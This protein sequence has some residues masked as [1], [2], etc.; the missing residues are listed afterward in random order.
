MVTNTS[1]QSFPN[2]YQMLKSPVYNDCLTEEMRA[3]FRRRDKDELRQLIITLAREL[4]AVV[5]AGECDAAV[6]AAERHPLGGNVGRFHLV[7]SRLQVACS[8][9]DCLF[10]GH[11]TAFVTD[12]INV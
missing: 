8:L 6:P 1:R 3:A 2:K 4:I 11:A 5:E 12:Y 9:Y 10:G 7:S